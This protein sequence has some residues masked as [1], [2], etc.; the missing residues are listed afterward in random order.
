MNLLRITL[1]R[2]FYIHGLSNCLLRLKRRVNLQI[3]RGI[4]V[5]PYTVTK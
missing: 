5:V 4:V 2:K 3:M 1:N